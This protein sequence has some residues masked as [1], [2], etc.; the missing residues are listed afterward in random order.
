MPEKKAP[1]KMS[2]S[3]RRRAAGQTLCC[4]SPRDGTTL[5]R[6]SASAQTNANGSTLVRLH[7]MIII[8]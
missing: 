7:R 4:I 5:N 3:W 2:K 8:R 6:Q 1:S